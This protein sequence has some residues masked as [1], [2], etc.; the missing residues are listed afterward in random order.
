MPS[1]G[2]GFAESLSGGLQNQENMRQRGMLE[3]MMLSKRIEME[4]QARQSEMAYAH[5]LNTLPQGG[6][7]ESLKVLG[8]PED[9]A[10]ALE[11]MFPEGAPQELLKDLGGP[12]GVQA[13]ANSY[14]NKPQKYTTKP[15]ANNVIIDGFKDP[16]TNEWVGQPQQILEPTAHHELEK[17]DVGVQNSMNMIGGILNRAKSVLT[18]APVGVPIQK[19]NAYW[20]SHGMPTN[21][22]LKAFQDSLGALSAQYIKD[23]TGMAPRSQQLME[24]DM[25]AFP[26]TSDDVQSAINKANILSEQMKNKAQVAHTTYDPLGLVPS[27]LHP[28]HQ[29][30]AIGQQNAAANTQHTTAKGTKYTVSQ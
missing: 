8:V 16:I 26:N 4:Q 1:F 23:T 7:A 21:P 13:R 9:K 10:Q 15:D 3:L 12:L 19:L 22:D 2:Q 5:K 18:N 27:P 29:G 28:M 20:Q 14:L 25:N 6:L 11:D 30:I 17:I 24:L